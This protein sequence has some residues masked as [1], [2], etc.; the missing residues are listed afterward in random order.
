MEACLLNLKYDKNEGK[1]LELDDI[2]LA[3]LDFR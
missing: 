1:I 3:A 2:E